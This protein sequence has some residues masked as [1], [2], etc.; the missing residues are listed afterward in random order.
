MKLRALTTA[1][2]SMYAQKTVRDLALAHVFFAL[3][4]TP[5]C[6]RRKSRQLECIVMFSELVNVV[7]L[8]LIESDIRSQCTMEVVKLNVETRSPKE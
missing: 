4:I 5:E 8:V 1:F 6:F 2:S 3:C 7:N